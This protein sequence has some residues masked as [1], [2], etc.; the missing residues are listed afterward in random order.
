MMQTPGPKDP[1]TDEYGIKWYWDNTTHGYVRYPPGG[2]DPDWSHA[3]GGDNELFNTDQNPLGTWEK[4]KNPT[5]EFATSKTAEYEPYGDDEPLDD[6]LYDEERE[7]EPQDDDIVIEHDGTIYAEGRVIGTVNEGWDEGY[8]MIYDWQ[9]RNQYYPT[10]WIISDHGNAQ[11]DDGY[12]QWVRKYEEETAKETEYEQSDKDAPGEAI[13]NQRFPS[14]RLKVGDLV[15][16]MSQAAYVGRIV[17]GPRWSADEGTPTSPTYREYLVAWEP[18]FRKYQQQP[19]E[20]TPEAYLQPAPNQD[21]SD[22]PEQMEQMVTHAN[23][24]GGGEQEDY[25]GYRNWDTWNVYTTMINDQET[26]HAAIQAARGGKEALEQWAIETIVGPHNQTAIEDAKEYNTFPMEERIDPDYEQLPPEG[27][28]I[29]DMVFGQGGNIGDVDPTLLDPFEIDWDHIYRN[30]QSTD[31]ELRESKTAEYQNTIQT[32]E[33]LDQDDMVPEHPTGCHCEQCEFRREM[34]KQQQVHPRTEPFYDKVPRPNMMNQDSY[35]PTMISKTQPL[36]HE[37]NGN[38]M[39]DLKQPHDWNHVF[40]KFAWEDSQPDLASCPECSL[41]MTSRSS[42]SFC[43]SC[44]HRQPHIYAN[45]KNAQGPL[46][47]PEAMAAGDALGIGGGEAAGAAG[48]GGLGGMMDAAMGKG[49]TML[50]GQGIKDLLGVGGGG[51]GAPS[52]G[53]GGEAPMAYAPGTVGHTAASDSEGNLGLAVNIDGQDVNPNIHSTD[54]L[55]NRA[56]DDPSDMKKGQLSSG[57]EGIVGEL[58]QFFDKLL[59]HVQKFAE[60]PEMDGSADKSVRALDALIESFNPGYRDQGDTVVIEA[61]PGEQGDSAIGMESDSDVGPGANE[62]S[63]PHNKESASP[64]PGMSMPDDAPMI[65]GRQNEEANVQAWRLQQFMQMGFPPEEAQQL[66]AGKM[67]WHQIQQ[68]VNQGA[69]PQDAVRILSHRMAAISNLEMEPHEALDQVL[70]GTMDYATLQQIIDE[71]RQRGE[72][73]QMGMGLPQGNSGYEMATPSNGLGQALSHVANL[74]MGQ[75]QMG[76]IGPPHPLGPAMQAPGSD[77]CE[78]CGGPHPSAMHDTASNGVTTEPLVAKISRRPKL[79]PYHSDVI[80]Y[81]LQFGDPREALSV[82]SPQMYG[83]QWCKSG[84]FHATC[85]FKPAM[86]KQEYWD[87]R[88]QELLQQRLDREQEVLQQPETPFAEV[89]EIEDTSFDSGEDTGYTPAE[90]TDIS[91][92]GAPMEMA[93]SARYSYEWTD[94]FGNPLIENQTYK[95][96]SPQY[97]APDDVTIKKIG[98]G[99]KLDVLI[100]SDLGIDY[101]EQYT[102]EK[103]D[104]NAF[105]FEP[106]PVPVQEQEFSPETN[107]ESPYYDDPGAVSDLSDLPTPVSHT[108]GGEPDQSGLHYMMDDSQAYDPATL[109]RVAGKDFTY[110]EQNAFINEAGRARNIEDMDLSGSHYGPLDAYLHD[111]SEEFSLGW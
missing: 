90:V 86:V 58:G 98:P 30:I 50:M 111:I 22:T 62:P 102:H 109:A 70:A 8:K 28:G 53:G 10:V 16:H 4:T 100:H 61:D 38:D 42:E 33:P 56:G 81:S 79:C 7:D 55:T 107:N 5:Q 54:G 94:A 46:L 67:D 17:D 29:A 76:Q 45:E 71:A 13:Y 18:P 39:S 93:A 106:E 49:K 3:T 104:T 57:A 60:D 74:P 36:I 32:P 105:Q 47:I 83:S 75:G 103:L 35:K 25:N 59:K 23:F 65:G 97:D 73:N 24:F 69:N 80:D 15:Y 44:G 101:E 20:W 91:A 63:E 84:E 72:G 99:D 52:G 87:N 64:L 37:P 40:D 92:V 9:T 82:I 41:P 43:G 89:E 108:E 31:Q 48:G 27:R 88:E 95:M 2:N 51:G 11:V 96:K 66:A 19:M 110:S 78:I 12:S 34:D 26:L 1:F 21:R 14:G 68:M 85:N 77:K 6:D